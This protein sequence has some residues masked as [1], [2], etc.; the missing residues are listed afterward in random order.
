MT[1]VFSGKLHVVHATMP[2]SSYLPGSYGEAI[3]LPIDPNLDRKHELQVRKV[4]ERSV[5]KYELPRSRLHLE[6]G[7]AQAILPLL[8]RRLGIDMVV[9][10]AMS[11]HGLDRLLI[12]S[13]A[14]RVI[15]KL[16]CDVLVVKLRNFKTSVAR[17]PP[18]QQPQ[19]P[20][21]EFP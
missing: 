11:R 21:P 15:D 17:K 1:T 20:E 12:G 2:L 19:L 9:M 18:R 3:A 7:D 14:E 8:A 4:V 5:A 13:T 16:H 10:G 6:L